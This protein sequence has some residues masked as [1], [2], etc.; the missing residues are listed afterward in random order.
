MKIASIELAGERGN[1]SVPDVFAT[2]RRRP[3][4]S[5]ILVSIATSDGDKDYWV[6]AKRAGHRTVRE[7]VESGDP[8]WEMAERL[9]ETLDGQV[10]SDAMVREYFD[11]LER[12][13]D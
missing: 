13:A 3:G 8:L 5:H 1:H 4:S 2:L 12:L 6:E 9:Q 10:G 7:R 11:L